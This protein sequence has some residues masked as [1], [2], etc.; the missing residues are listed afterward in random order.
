[1]ESFQQD[2]PQIVSVPSQ[3]LQS[4]QPSGHK[5]FFFIVLVIFLLVGILA[6]FFSRT[7]QGQRLIN[8][9]FPSVDRTLFLARSSAESFLPYSFNAEMT[10][11]TSTQKSSGMVE[12]S[13]NQEFDLTYSNKASTLISS[14]WTA[15]IMSGGGSIYGQDVYDGSYHDISDGVE[16]R[17]PIREILF[18]TPK[19]L[20][21]IISPSQLHDIVFTRKDSS[22]LLASTVIASTTSPYKEISSI[23]FS[24]DS[25]DYHITSF[26]IKGMNNA[27][28]PFE[29]KS[30]LKIAT[31]DTH[32]G[33]MPEKVNKFG[34]FLARETVLMTTN[35]AKNY[36]YLWPL[37]ENT[38]F[39]CTKCVNERADPDNDGL[40]NEL[41]FLFG[42]D[43]YK[44]LSEKTDKNDLD[45]ITRGINPV[46]GNIIP[47]PYFAGALE[48]IKNHKSQSLILDKSLPTPSK[49]TIR[50]SSV[51]LPINFM[52]TVKNLMLRY[53][54]DLPKGDYI[55]VFIGDQ[56]VSTIIIDG[57]EGSK[58]ISIPIDQFA[59]KTENLTIILNPYGNLHLTLKSTAS[60]NVEVLGIRINPLNP[61]SPLY[62]Q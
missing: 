50:D 47:E 14:L 34:D 43:P 35:Q 11:G 30:D 9:Y 54:S 32:I 19:N 3:Q 27:D 61:K 46:T 39:K 62:L 16:N 41:E 49:F 59:G 15:H 42:T 38:Y 51:L 48:L 33:A 17:L 22:Y 25:N 37:W 7:F 52:P 10:I 8:K 56:K 58:T 24:I 60:F 44:A 28:K 53:T 12:T 5:K 26:D 1:M 20:L 55:T 45:A 23:E 4:N 6:F 57:T 18:A 13:D 21:E 2:P 40:I 36:D 29:L 31:A